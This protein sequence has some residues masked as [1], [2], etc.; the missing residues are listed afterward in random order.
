MKIK[1]KKRSILII[2]SDLENLRFKTS[3]PQEAM[4]FIKGTKYVL[5]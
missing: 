5:F 4:G 1:N 2:M 3:F